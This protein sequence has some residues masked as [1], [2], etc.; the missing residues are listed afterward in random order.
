M[1]PSGP[2]LVFVGGV[3]LLFIYRFYF[4]SN[5][6]LFKLSI[7]FWLN[8]GGL[9][10]S[11]NLSLFSGLLNLLAYNCSLYS[12]TVFCISVVSVET[13]ILFL[14]LFTWVLYP[15][16]VS[17]ANGSSIL[18]TLSISFLISSFPQSSVGKESTCNARDPGSIPGSG[19]S[20]GEGIGY[21][22]LPLWLS[23]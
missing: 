6:C 1:K 11:E 21:P 22:G 13:S 16:L 2:A 7:S 5:D 8:F 10:V 14:T 20:A 12:L 4:T 17:V 19:R 15:F 18:F 9:Y 23:W 3:F